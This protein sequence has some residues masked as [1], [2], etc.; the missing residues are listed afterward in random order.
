MFI[1]KKRTLAPISV[2][3]TTYVIKS[4]GID[5]MK[6]I[7]EGVEITIRESNSQRYYFIFNH[8]DQ[9]QLITIMGGEEQL[10]PFG[11]H[12]YRESDK[13]RLL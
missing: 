3:H 7:P 11:M 12:I 2:F 10:D 1:K 4:S 9:M 8:T 13:Y 5:Y 6:D